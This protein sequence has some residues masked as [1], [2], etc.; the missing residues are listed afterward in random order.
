MKRKRQPS[1]ASWIREHANFH[2]PKTRMEIERLRDGATEAGFPVSFSGAR[3]AFYHALKQRGAKKREKGAVRHVVPGL[4]L[5]NSMTKELQ[6][7]TQEVQR[8]RKVE[9]AYHTIVAAVE[10]Q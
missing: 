10:K 9:Q 4:M 2:A 3:S 6:L 5:I 7:L 1:A 8:L